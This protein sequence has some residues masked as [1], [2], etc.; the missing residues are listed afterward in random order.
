[1]NLQK[2]NIQLQPRFL[3][4]KTKPLYRHRLHNQYFY[5]DEVREIMFGDD[6]KTLIEYIF[7]L[8]EGEGPFNEESL[9]YW[10]FKNLKNGYT[11]LMCRNH[12]GTELYFENVHA[13]DVQMRDVSLTLNKNI[14]RLR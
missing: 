9:Q 2:L 3:P 8:Q 14:L 13:P 6:T 4:F 12:K 11:M 1:M 5:T 7:E 10:D